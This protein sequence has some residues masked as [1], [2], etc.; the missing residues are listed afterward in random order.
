M[1]VRVRERFL[2]LLAFLLPLLV[3]KGWAVFMKVPTPQT[4]T[5]GTTANTVN[6]TIGSDPKRTWSRRERDAGAHILL[7]DVRQFGPSPLDHREPPPPDPPPAT[8]PTIIV[9]P[10]GNVKLVRPLV[11]LQLIWASDRVNIALIDGKRYREGDPLKE[12][13]WIVTEIDGLKR[14][15]RLESE[16]GEQVEYLFIDPPPKP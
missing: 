12:T 9:Q 4:A 3:V 16:D 15:V 1:N 2:F 8:Q 10:G 11:K 13:G 6:T 7:L 14:R 5:A